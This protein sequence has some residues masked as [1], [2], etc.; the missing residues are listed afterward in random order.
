MPPALEWNEERQH[1][2]KTA[3]DLA[4]P[5]L[6]ALRKR[7]S[8]LTLTRDGSIPKQSR[9]PRR[10]SAIPSNPPHARMRHSASTNDE[11]ERLVAEKW[12]NAVDRGKFQW[13]RPSISNGGFQ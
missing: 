13:P 8:I 6:V 1:R 7:I 9:N 5:V 3:Q 2:R 12:H 11:L 10:A 4:N